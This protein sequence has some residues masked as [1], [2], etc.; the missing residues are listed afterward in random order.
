VRH[1]AAVVGAPPAGARIWTGRAAGA[2]GVW[3]GGPAGR[4]AGLAAAACIALAGCGGASRPR[5]SATARHP[6]ATARHPH[7]T[8]TARA[9]RA[10][11]ARAQAGHEFPSPEPAPQNASGGS[12]SAEDAIRAFAQAYINWSA[13]TVAADMRALAARCVGQARSALELAAAQTAADYELQRDG[14]ANSGTV[15][16][17]APLPG[18]R[19]QYAVLTRESTTATNTT[20]YQGLRPAW[21]VTI[22]TVQQLRPGVWVVSGWQPEV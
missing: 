5:A 2:T 16:A 15:E 9:L 8:G 20:A 18:S 4:I 21:H 14:I 6:H 13:G 12:R 3:P 17:I 22:A 1:P 7:A 11:I 10:E 19:S